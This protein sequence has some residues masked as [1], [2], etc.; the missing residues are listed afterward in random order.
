[1]PGHLLTAAPDFFL[2]LLPPLTILT[3]LLVSPFTKVEESFSLQ[4]THDIHRHGLPTKDV[5]SYLTARYDHLTFPGAVPRSFVGPLLLSQV[6]VPFI[7]LFGGLVNEQVIGPLPIPPCR[8][9]HSL[10]VS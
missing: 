7:H 9:T 6:S 3:H 2:H 5:A 4:A 10:H 8:L 1:M